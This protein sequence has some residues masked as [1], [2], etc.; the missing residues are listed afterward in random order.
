MSA[1]L[2][3]RDVVITDQGQIGSSSTGTGFAGDI[4]IQA[5]E[6][7]LLVN[8]KIS[9][10]AAAGNGG[11][12]TIVAGDLVALNNSEI[13][14]TVAS[15][16]GNGGNI[17]IDPIFIVLVDS[18]IIANASAG[19]GGN[20]RLTA[21]HI[22]ADDQSIVSA[23]SDLGID[24]TVAIDAPDTDLTGGLTTLNADF[25][26]AAALLA[27]QCAARGG[28]TVASLTATGR[29]G[30]PSGPNQYQAAQFFVGAN[31]TVA[32]HSRTETAAL[33]GRERGS[34]RVLSLR[35]DS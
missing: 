23:S 35:C 31:A 11:N 25:L 8:A 20:I 29:G 26:N 14:T 21:D 34:F 7:L 27:Q 6:K 22:L 13:T 30:L 18:R 32:R 24:G 2:A 5:A 1:L 28:Q 12:I 3:A 19:S 9:A 16:V 33:T 17:D 15:N 4:V 10:E